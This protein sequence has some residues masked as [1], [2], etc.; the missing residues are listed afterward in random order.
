MSEQPILTPRDGLKFILIR[1]DTDAGMAQ[2]VWE[3][4]KDIQRHLSWLQYINRAR[5][6]DR[7]R[8]HLSQQTERPPISRGVNGKCLGKLKK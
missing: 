7:A 6:R 2:G 1:Y 3:V 8:V 4:V 5:E